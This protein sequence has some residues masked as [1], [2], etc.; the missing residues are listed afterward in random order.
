[1]AQLKVIH[2]RNKCIG[3][4][5]CVTIAPQNWTMDEVE[6]K[7]RLAGAKEK[8][9]VFVGEIFECD[10]IDNKRAAEACPMNIIK[11]NSN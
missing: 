5:V 1:M 10:L 6:G 3:C 9:G 2:Q 11:I 8:R 4:N 7:S